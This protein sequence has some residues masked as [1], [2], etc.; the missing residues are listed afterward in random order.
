MKTFKLEIHYTY[1][2]ELNIVAESLEEAKYLAMKNC[3]HGGPEFHT[4]L[5]EDVLP[6]Y[7]ADYHPINEQ[8]YKR[9]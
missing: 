8:I 5:D 6:Y 7:S 2:V 4:T 1:K 3:G 9:K